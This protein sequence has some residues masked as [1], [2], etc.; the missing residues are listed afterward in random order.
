[1]I[2]SSL[3]PGH[4]VWSEFQGFKA[5]C[6][7]E[8]TVQSKSSRHEWETQFCMKHIKPLDGFRGLAVLLVILRHWQFPFLNLELGW[9]GVNLF[10]VLS[11]FLIS[12]ILIADKKVLSLSGY[13][14]VFFL[15]RT[16]RIFPI[17]YLY[18]ILAF[19]FLMFVNTLTNNVE[20][21]NAARHLRHNWPYLLTYTYNFHHAMDLFTGVQTPGTKFFA[22]LWSLSVEEQ[23]YVFFPFV[24]YF[25]SHK[26]LR[27]LMIAII[28]VSPFIRVIF[29]EYLITNGYNI[30]TSGLA[31]YKSTIF[32]LDSLATGVLL[33]TLDMERVK[34]SSKRFIW[35]MALIGA[36][37][38][39]TVGFMRAVGVN[40]AY[41]SLTFQLL[42]E[43]LAYRTNT[44]FDHYYAL[45]FTVVNLTS[46]IVIVAC[47]K[48]L[49]PI[50]FMEHRYLVNVGKISYGMYLYHNALYLLF[51]LGAIHYFGQGYIAS[52][53]WLEVVL[54][55]IYFSMVLVISRLSFSYIESPFLRLKDRV[56][57]K[58]HR[59]QI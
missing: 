15:K 6:S 4:N 22:H 10:F 41:S 35:V 56:S 37:L 2:W 7:T 57:R 34:L 29:G 42:S 13:L 47:I 9:I 50:R 33:A 32:Q 46:A 25:L 23:F 8:G 19:I 44:I 21:A 40:M 39:V 38:L 52:N 59:P 54:F 49:R 31:I 3:A 1:M 17:Y 45:T 43:S 55:A 16:F 28:A 36:L 12:S 14:K 53:W 27:N 20:F 11:G 58:V 26:S 5:V 24:V 30:H 48:G 18:L 51:S